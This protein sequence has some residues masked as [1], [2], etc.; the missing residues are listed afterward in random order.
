M[1]TRTEELRTLVTASL[2]EA[3]ADMKVG[4]T[5]YAP[6]GY[7]PETVRKSCSELKAKGYI[8]TTNSRTGRQTVTRLK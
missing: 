3:L 5:C 6:K 2:P 4:E 1:N 7:T 8:F